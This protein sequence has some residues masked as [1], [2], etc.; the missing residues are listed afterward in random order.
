M[1][2]DM[3]IKKG[4]IID[5]K[6]QERY[7]GDIGISKGKITQINRTISEDAKSIIDATNHIVCPGFIDIHSHSDMALPFSNRLES[8]LHQG[9]TTTVIGNCGFSLAP[10]NE[11]RID[12]M[13]Q[14]FEIYAPPETSLEISWRTFT[15]YLEY[16]ERTKVSSNIVSLVGF[17]AV[18]IA[19]GPAYENRE[20]T[21]LEL[22]E[23]KGYVDEAMMAG[24]FGMSTGL[25]YPPQV[26]ASTKEIIELT[27]VVAKHRGLYFSHIR[28]EGEAVL[29]AVSEVIDIVERSGCIGGQ[30]AHH[31]VAGKRVWGKSVETLQL[32]ENANQ[33]GISVTCDQYPYDRGSTSL[34]SVLPPWV[35]IGGVG[36]LLDRL[37]SPDDRKRIIADIEDEDSKWENI[38]LEA[39]WENIFISS[40]KT[41][42]WKDME[43]LNISAI[44][45][46]KGYPDEYSVLFEL[47]IDENA[48]VTMTMRSMHDDDIERIMKHELVMVGTDGSGVSPEG[49][50]SYGKPHPR[51]YGTYPRILGRYVREKKIL[52]LEN[53][54]YKM[55]GFPAKRLGLKDRG[56]LEIG[57]WADIV[58]FNADTVI[59]NAT[60]LEPHQFPTGI[61]Y[62]IVNGKIV[63]REGIQGDDLPGKVL[64]RE[65]S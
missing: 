52:S 53:A 6:N 37:R 40:V 7:S 14:E 57:N 48:E 34:I 15:D 24:A 21:K 8:T 16:I 46:K 28:G 59:D 45:S 4:T 9:I 54:V 1:K 38:K 2:L 19:G 29:K 39:G 20:P 27:K 30:I 33:R 55:S 65:Q 25:I 13:K 32:I 5:G 60:F 62:V 56:T 36:E 35:H 49:V 31:K 42:K 22:E 51:H 18:R 41:E 10:V 11:E 23:M 61:P 58:V 50:L 3:L 12:L 44:T 17:G 64:R 63:V 47:L 26:Y 43:G